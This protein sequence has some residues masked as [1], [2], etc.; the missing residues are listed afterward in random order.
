VVTE[1]ACVPPRSLAVGVPAKVKREL[2]DDEI[3]S[4]LENAAI[5]VGN[6]KLYRRTN[7]ES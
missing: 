1:G 7:H 6:A 3:A 2:T 5:Y 4:I